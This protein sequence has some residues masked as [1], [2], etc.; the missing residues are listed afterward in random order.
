MSWTLGELVA[1]VGATRADVRDVRDG[2]RCV[3]R[4]D[5]P[6]GVKEDAGTSEVT[7]EQDERLRPRSDSGPGGRNQDRPWGMQSQ[8]PTVVDVHEHERVVAG[9]VGPAVREDRRDDAALLRRLQGELTHIAG[10]E[11]ED[12]P[13]QWEAGYRRGSSRRLRH[14]A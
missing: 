5:D 3:A 11:V 9:E 7:R 10:A 8:R 6:P 4:G 1:E 2:A 12:A 13:G 14:R